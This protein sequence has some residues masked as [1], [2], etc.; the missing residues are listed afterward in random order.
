LFFSI[1]KSYGIIFHFISRDEFFINYSLKHQYA[2]PIN[3]VLQF[4]Q[5]K[6]STFLIPFPTIF[7]IFVTVLSVLFEPLKIQKKWNNLDSSTVY[8]AQRIRSEES[9]YKTKNQPL[10]FLPSARGGTSCRNNSYIV[11]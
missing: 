3:F 9:Y 5:T 1:S 6:G 11:K 2:I 8:S 10:S 7:F 4:I